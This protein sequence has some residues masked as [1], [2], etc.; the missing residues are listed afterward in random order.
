[1]HG[2]AV[3]THAWSDTLLRN[4]SLE[5]CRI[6]SA[7]LPKSIALALRG[8][9]LL[10]N[11]TLSPERG[12]NGNPHRCAQP[13]GRP[14]TSLLFAPGPNAKVFDSSP[15]DDR[16]W[17]LLE[18]MFWPGGLSR[19]P[20]CEGSPVRAA[21]VRSTS[22]MH[23][24]VS[25]S[26]DTPDTRRHVPTA[27]QGGLVGVRAVGCRDGCAVQRDQ[28]WGTACAPGGEQAVVWGLGRIILGPTSALRPFL[29][30]HHKATVCA[31]GRTTQL[32]YTNCIAPHQNARNM[33]DHTTSETQQ[34]KSNCIK[35][36][37][38]TMHYMTP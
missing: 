13:K 34:A 3:P 26:H 9:V 8:T 25:S 32:G 29:A 33:P 30:H 1:M 35:M 23:P 21:H 12:T 27:T 18:I 22:A 4:S 20:P 11:N 28:H 19:A 7:A 24:P 10:N 31:W 36:H 17:S 14:A 6:P 15:D 37:R 2:S 5:D 16:P 38:N